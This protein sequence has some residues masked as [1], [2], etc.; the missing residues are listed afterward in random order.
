MQGREQRILELPWVTPAIF[1]GDDQNPHTE[2]R[3][4]RS[5]VYNQENWSF[6]PPEFLSTFT[7]PINYNKPL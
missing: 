3:A 6:K 5:Y 4:L 1:M 2:C 7:P